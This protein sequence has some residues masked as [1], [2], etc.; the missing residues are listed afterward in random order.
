MKVLHSQSASQ[1]QF[2]DRNDVCQ[3]YNSLEGQKRSSVTQRHV[4]TWVGRCNNF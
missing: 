4:R 3:H 1:P 2:S